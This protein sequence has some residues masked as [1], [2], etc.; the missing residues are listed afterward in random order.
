LMPR[1][2]KRKNARSEQ[3]VGDPVFEIQVGGH[4]KYSALVEGQF[5]IRRVVSMGRCN[6]CSKTS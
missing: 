1:S 4:R 5:P 6:T 2:R 3:Q